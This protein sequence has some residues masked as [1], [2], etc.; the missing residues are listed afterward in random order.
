MR[1]EGKRR[2]MTGKTNK[3]EWKGIGEKEGNQLTEVYI[4]HE[5]TSRCISIRHKLVFMNTSP[6]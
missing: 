1:G 2:G 6:H 3:R 5:D 4:T